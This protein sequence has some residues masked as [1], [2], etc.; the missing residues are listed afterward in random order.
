MIKN[1][2]F[3]LHKVA[4]ILARFLMQRELIRQIF[5]KPLKYQI[6]RKFLS[7]SR[8][9]LCGQTDT[10]K[11]SVTFRSFAIA[12]K[13]STSSRLRPKR[14]LVLLYLWQNTETDE[15]L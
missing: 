13:S 2:I 1:I 14:L 5:E 6:S 15:R 9:V 12:P 3:S 11:L 4:V 8:D 10:T 7:G